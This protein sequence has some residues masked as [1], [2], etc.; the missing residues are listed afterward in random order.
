MTCARQKKRSV[1]VEIDDAPKVPVS[2]AGVHNFIQK[3]D[4]QPFL[5]LKVK[6]QCKF[7]GSCV[8]LP[9]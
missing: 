3:K 7:C 1:G 9:L 5:R 6:L 2:Y 8:K 4:I